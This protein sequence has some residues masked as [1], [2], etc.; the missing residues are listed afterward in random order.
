[1][2]IDKR[3][4]DSD[5]F[6][7]YFKEEPD[8]QDA[9]EGVLEAASD[10]KILIV[11]SALTL[12]EVL[13]VQKQP[14]LPITLRKEIDN[15]FKQP[16]ISVQNVTRKIADDARDL[17]WDHNVKPK[18]AIHLATALACKLQL[19]NTFDGKLL[20][21]NNELGNPNLK[22]EKPHEKTQRKLDLNH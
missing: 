15:F 2:A 9:C 10:G 18:D 3:Y 17:V 1:M 7:G 21:L 8:K 4:W 16:Y 5:A 13:Y 12:A 20:S 6:L 22:I 14:K 19:L 11:T